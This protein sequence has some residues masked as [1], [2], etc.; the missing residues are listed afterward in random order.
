[1]IVDFDK[2]PDWGKL[3]VFPASRKFYSQEINEVK[4][5]IESFL[6]TWNLDKEELKSAY[7]IKYDRFIIITIDDS[8]ITLPLETHDALSDFI[9][10]LEKKY[11]ILLLDKI[12]VCYKQGEFVQYKDLIA[13]KKMIK[14]KSISP[15]IT[16]FNN[17]ISTK[18]ELSNQWEINI[19]DSYLGHFFK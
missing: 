18:E 16:V 7:Q 19:M 12:N 4:E 14:S 17:M 11:N 1:M 13:F 10:S 6:K 8:E 2:I 5:S 15:K 3:W 9:Q